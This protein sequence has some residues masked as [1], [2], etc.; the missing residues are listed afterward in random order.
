[1]SWARPATVDDADALTARALKLLARREHSALELTRKLLRNGG[2]A[3]VRA[4]VEG[5]AQRGFLSDERFVESYVRNRIERGQ[6]PAK[7]RAGLLARGVTSALIDGALGHAAEFWYERART[8][9]AKR[10]GVA[11]PA[12]AAERGRRTRFLSMRGY[13]AD[14][15]YRAASGSEAGQPV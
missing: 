12:D 14:I 7:I 2:D 11:P 13:P 4:V 15:A 1:M 3:T 5:L 9:L 10:F 8:A 6:G